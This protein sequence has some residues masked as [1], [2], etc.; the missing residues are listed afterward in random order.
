MLYHVDAWTVMCTD[1]AQL[2]I[3]NIEFGYYK[4]FYI[5][6]QFII[7]CRI[8]GIWNFGAT[9]PLTLCCK[10]LWSTSG[11]MSNYNHDHGGYILIVYLTGK[12]VLKPV[13]YSKVLTSTQWED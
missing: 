12:L 7:I 10:L 8:S 13:E 3:V 5:I 1:I 4:Y 11:A 9:Y 6:Y 2:N